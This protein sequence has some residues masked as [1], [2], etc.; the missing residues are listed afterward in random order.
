[1]L[2]AVDGQTDPK[3]VLTK[4]STCRAL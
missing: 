3:L 4:V 2:V 1:L